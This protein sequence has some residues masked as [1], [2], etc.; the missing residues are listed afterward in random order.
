LNWEPNTPLKMG[1]KTTYQWIDQQ[2]Y[3]RK[4]GKRVVED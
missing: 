3:D 2:Y 1:L 4:A